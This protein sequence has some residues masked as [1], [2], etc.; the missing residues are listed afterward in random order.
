[1]LTIFGQ[2]VGAAE[3]GLKVITNSQRANMEKI[4][5]ILEERVTR[6]LQT[7]GIARLQPDTIY[8]ETNAEVRLSTLMIIAYIVD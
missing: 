6:Q 8:K 2:G 4:E 5:K 3:E 1:M 7:L